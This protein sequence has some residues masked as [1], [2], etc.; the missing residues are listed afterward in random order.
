MY[1]NNA[2]RGKRTT[3]NVNPQSVKPDLSAQV[4]S[5]SPEAMPMISLLEKI[6][7]GPKPKNK[8]VG[9][10]K[11]Y[12]FD[13]LDTATAVTV[14]T[15]GEE[16]FAQLTMAQVSRPQVRGAMFYQPQDKLTIVE[17]G[18]VV[19]V[20]I[21][22]D[23]AYK[24]NGSEVTLTA[25]LTGGTTTRS[26]AGTICVRV[27][28]PV[29]FIDPGGAT[30]TY[31]LGRTIWESQP[32]EAVGVMEDELFDFNFVEHKETVVEATND[33]IE[34]IE[35]YGGL[36]ST[37]DFSFQQKQTFSNMK[38]D[39]N[40]LSFW[41]ER[42]VN[43][44]QPS[45]PTY[46]MRGLMNAIQT[47]VTVYNPTA[48]ADFENLVSEFMYKQ[49]FRYN[50]GSNRKMAFCGPNF[51]HNFNKAF[52][53]YRR[54]DIN[55]SKQMPGLDIQTYTWMG[56]TLDLV[57]NEIFR[58]DTKHADWCVVVDPAQAELRVAKNFE[59]FPYNL[60]NERE[61]KIASEWQGTIA[62]HLEEHHALLRTA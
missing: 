59:T 55:V 54:S 41:G 36:G 39:V 8:R 16:R 58:L 2:R 5:L 26:A 57:R 38:K 22:P 46:H 49:A 20:W 24:V 31:F 13:H 17:T 10:R 18:Q 32:V 61:K 21:T 6:G 45:R 43:F 25:G 15:A 1:Q 50:N 56:Y 12:A 4:R 14:G 3:T 47:N 33:Q 27:V 40:Y 48:T 7:S 42:A 9:T 62:W 30:D 29:N 44:D 23:A 35:T 34:F 51:L 53:E 28:E 19:E 60:A 52:R 11:H 37:D